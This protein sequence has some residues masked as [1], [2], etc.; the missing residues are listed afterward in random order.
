[1]VV[2]LVSFNK[3]FVD[4]SGGVVGFVFGGVWINVFVFFIVVFV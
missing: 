2:R 1:M 3:L 4:D